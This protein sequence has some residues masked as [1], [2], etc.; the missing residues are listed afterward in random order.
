MIYKI[1]AK[2][3]KNLREFFKST[4]ENISKELN[5]CPIILQALTFNIVAQYM[6]SRKKKNSE[7][8]SASTYSGIRSALAFIHKAAGFKPLPGFTEN[9]S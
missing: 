5:N 7:Y 1:L 4:L 6:T 3:R 9:M 8:H 2:K